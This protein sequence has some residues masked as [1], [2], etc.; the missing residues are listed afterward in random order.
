MTVTM[1]T[2]GYDIALSVFLLLLRLLLLQ[3]QR[4]PV[5]ACHTTSVP[6]LQDP[7][8]DRIRLSIYLKS[9]LLIQKGF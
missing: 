7:I 9:I 5:A 2:G 8:I 4:Q 1:L 6:L 3:H